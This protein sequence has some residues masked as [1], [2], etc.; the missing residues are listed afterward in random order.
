MKSTK[1]SLLLALLTGGGVT[2]SFAQM[3]GEYQLQPIVTR[4]AETAKKVTLNAGIHLFN[5]VDLQEADN[6]DGYTVDM[7]LTIPIPGTK[8]WQVRLGVPFYTAGTARLTK[9]GEPDTGKEIDIRGYGGVFDFANIQVEYQFLEESVKGF[10]AAAYGGI[11]ERL[12]YLKTSTVADDKYNHKGLVG[13]MGLKGDVHCGEDWRFAA[14]L[15]ARY[16]FKSDDLNPA[17]TSTSGSVFWLVEASFAAIYHPWKAPVFPV[18]ELLY[19]GV[20]SDYNSVLFVPEIIYAI[21]SHVELK[22]GAPIG[23]TGDGESF[24]GRFQITTRF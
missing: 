19:Q 24:G 2:A 17:D 12:D 21:N 8:H 10:N 14:N 3:E 11:G 6:F 5:D 13:L 18:A 7:D 22:A 9:T 1:I 16:Y 4:Y 20:I 23:L 15:G